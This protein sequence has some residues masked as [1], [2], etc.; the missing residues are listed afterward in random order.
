MPR[1]TRPLALLAVG[2]SLVLLAGCGTAS[3]PSPTATLEAT[4]S[5]DAMEPSALAVCRGQDVTLNVHAQTNA[6]FHLHGFDDQVP[7]IGLTPGETT[8]FQFT[9]DV[10]GQ[11]IFELHDRSGA[12]STDIGVLT[13]NEP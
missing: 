12:T 13:V 7:A 1:A 9:A 5:D 4:V 11:F 10:A 8:T 3:C 2:A 6:V